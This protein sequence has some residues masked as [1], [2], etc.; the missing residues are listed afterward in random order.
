MQR[1]VEHRLET[2][3]SVLATRE[4]ALARRFLRDGEALK[5]WC[6]DVQKRHYERLN[7]GDTGAVQSSTY[8]LDMFNALRRIS[9]HLNSIGHTFATAKSA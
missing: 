7:P 8:F 5:N 4:R 1:R 6:I 2:A 3:I 9:G